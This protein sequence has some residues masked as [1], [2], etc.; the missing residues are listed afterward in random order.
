M[1]VMRLNYSARRRR[2]VQPSLAI[3]LLVAVV[4][5]VSETSVATLLGRV[6]AGHHLGLIYVLGIL[7]ISA[8][9]GVGLG[10]FVAV[11]SAVACDLFLTGPAWS[12]HPT[13]SGFLATLAIFVL[14]SLLAGV[15]PVLTRARGEPPAEA[16]PGSVSGEEAVTAPASPTTP[17]PRPRPDDPPPGPAGGADSDRENVAVREDYDMLC[18]I[19]DEQVA[20]RNLATFVAHNAPPSD[21]FDA[22][23]RELA[24]I[25]GT[26]HTV[27]A[28]YEPN[29]TS[30]V[31]TGTW[32]YEQITPSGTRWKLEKGTVAEL[33][34]RTSPPSRV[35]AYPRAGQLTTRLC[36]RGVS[37][38]VGC[39]IIVGCDLWGVAIASSVTP[40]EL[41]ADTEERMLH[42]TELA[43]AAIA[44]AQSTS[45]LIAAQA[46]I[47]TAAAEPRRRLER[48][49]HDGAQQNLVSIGLRI[50]AI[51]A[52]LPPQATECQHQLSDIAQAVDNTI[53]E[54]QEISR[55]MCP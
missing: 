20:L 15:V 9:W 51:E 35:S 55:G 34:F 6:T 33:G 19:A 53:E 36:Q 41:P 27:I 37:S 52:A 21:V 49:L 5:L 32:N 46:R 22:V 45:D 16:G 23:A 13:A 54:L 24:Q 42:F 48:D 8:W 47:L 4:C 44:N 50:R 30:V 10:I 2:R 18:R 26:E 39:P 14:V 28:R 1:C 29:G 25:L 38:S 3:G 7:L 43:G 17:A 31:V 11:A 40:V 12:A